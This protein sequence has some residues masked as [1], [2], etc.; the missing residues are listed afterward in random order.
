MAG[1]RVW[2]AMITISF[3][4]VPLHKQ[5]KQG[6]ELFVFVY[7]TQQVAGILLSKDLTGG[8]K[9]GEARVCVP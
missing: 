9:R 8:D 1:P 4:V 7:D 5:H 2:D 6:I 3:E